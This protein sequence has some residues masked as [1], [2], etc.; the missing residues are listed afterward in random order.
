MKSPSLIYPLMINSRHSHEAS[1][2][3]ENTI[4]NTVVTENLNSTNNGNRKKG[5]LKELKEMKND[6]ILKNL[7]LVSGDLKPDESKN[8]VQKAQKKV[9]YA[10]MLLKNVK[11]KV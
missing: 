9:I 2:V 1:T 4:F 3:G 8:V 5:I 6:S 10:N 7:K 11:G